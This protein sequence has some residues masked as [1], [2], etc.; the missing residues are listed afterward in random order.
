MK[1]HV[2]LNNQDLV[3]FDPSYKNIVFGI[4]WQYQNIYYPDEKWS[5]RG[6]GVLGCWIG[7][8]MDFLE[9]KTQGQFPFLEGPY[10]IAA[11]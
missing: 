2:N 5:D 10:F 1:I 11:Q 7:T 6:I 9:G 4:N 3:K 8:I